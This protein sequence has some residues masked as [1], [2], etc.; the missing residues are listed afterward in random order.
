MRIALVHQHVPADAPADERD[1]LEQVAA[2]Q[3]A[4]AA[5]GHATSTLPCT[6]DLANLQRKL[7]VFKPDCVFNLVET[8]ER[9]VREP[10]LAPRFAVAGRVGRT[11]GWQLPLGSR[12]RPA[13]GAGFL[14][15]GG[16][17]P[18]FSKV[19]NIPVFG[20]MLLP[21]K[22]LFILVLGFCVAHTLNDLL[23]RFTDIDLRERLEE[24]LDR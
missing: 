18:L 13:S 9:L 24:R 14:L 23:A 6:T 12:R 16:A 2:I 3:T 21:V 19:F 15:L 20:T 7:E 4:L 22:L 1:V 8:L 10:F 5:E 11:V 17:V